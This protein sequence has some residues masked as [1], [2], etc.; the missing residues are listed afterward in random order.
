MPHRPSAMKHLRADERKRQR[1]IR[2]KSAMRKAVKEAEEA[3]SANA[4]NADEVFRLAVKKLDKS[5]S[6]GVIK[7]GKANRKKSRLAKKLDA[8]KKS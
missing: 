4:P 8:M 5:V 3:I 6:K 7:K 2:I 1:N